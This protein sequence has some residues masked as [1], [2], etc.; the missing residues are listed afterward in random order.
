MGVKTGNKNDSWQP[1]PGMY[2]P[3]VDSIKGDTKSS[4]FGGGNRSNIAAARQGPGPGAYNTTNYRNTNANSYS[5]GGSKR[6]S[7]KDSGNPGPGQYHVPYYVADV[8]RYQMPNRPE[9][10]RFV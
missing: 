2:D 6:Q 1:G 4:R 10:W 3:I 8:P 9:E 5:I 7:A